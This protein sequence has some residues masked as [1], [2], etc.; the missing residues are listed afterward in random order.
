[1][2]TLTYTFT[3]DDL[4]VQPAGWEVHQ[5]GA[6]TPVSQTYDIAGSRKYELN[7][8]GGIRASCTDITVELEDVIIS[9]SYG[10][11]PF[12]GTG[13][14]WVRYGN[15]TIASGTFDGYRL[16]ITANGV[17]N[18]YLTI[19]K[20][21]AGS[22]S[23]LAQQSV[24]AAFNSFVDFKFEVT[25]QTIRG[26][27][28]VNGD[29]EPAWQVSTT[30][31]SFSTG[32]IL[33]GSAGTGSSMFD[34]LSIESD[35]IVIDVEAAQDPVGEV[36][37]T[38]YN[39]VVYQGITV[40]PRGSGGFS[41]DIKIASFNP[42]IAAQP[43]NVYP[44]LGTLSISGLSP[45]VVGQFNTTVAQDPLGTISITGYNPVVAIQN[46][47][48]PVGSI[49]IT[50]FNPTVDAE[51]S[52]VHLY[53][54][55]KDAAGNVWTREIDSKPTVAEVTTTYIASSRD[56]IILA[57]A[58]GGAFNVTLPAPTGR[59][60]LIYRIKKIDSSVNAVTVV[61]TIDEDSNFDL[62]AE[63]ESITVTSDGTEWWII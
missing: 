14:I 44:T 18:R 11:F 53:I 52:N 33:L 35:D 42:T 36:T 22:Y 27:L 49:V 43:T 41:G 1:V 40:V 24:A 7:C 20:Y 10:L 54:K 17:S 8:S 9:G 47:S 32:S 39:P 29:A 61:G 16:A 37:V 26:K 23:Q 25:G 3:S 2:A 51:A 59:T 50:G 31:A 15:G 57:D 21:L 30:D 4:Y 34:N 12:G 60:G 13:Q 28:W 48:S 55:F 38:G 56:E 62:I 19:G 6:G 58:T 63:D 46:I 45:T 5:N